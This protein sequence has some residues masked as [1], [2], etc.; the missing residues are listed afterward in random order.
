M[1]NAEHATDREL[2]FFAAFFG[3]VDYLGTGIRG[4]CAEVFIYSMSSSDNWANLRN[5]LLAD[6][7]F[8]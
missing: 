5:Y 2:R 8:V 7:A 3:P 1:Q 4:V 6:N